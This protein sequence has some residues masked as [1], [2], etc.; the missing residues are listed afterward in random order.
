MKTPSGV[1]FWLSYL[2]ANPS[3]LESKVILTKADGV[4][5]LRSFKGK[6][7]CNGWESYAIALEE[8]G[9][10]YGLWAQLRPE[11]I[12]SAVQVAK[13][14]QD[15][16]CRYI[17]FAC[18]TSWKGHDIDAR[19]LLEQT[20]A[21]FD[22]AIGISMFGKAGGVQTWP[23]QEFKSADFLL[24]Q[25]YDMNESLGDNYQ[26]EVLK[27]WRDA[28]YSNVNIGLSTTKPVE[29]FTQD[30]DETP[31]DV[32]AVCWWEYSRTSAD[33]A[34]ALST[35]PRKLGF[36]EQQQEDQGR[37][38]VAGLLAGAAAAAGIL[39]VLGRANDD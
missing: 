2:P 7:Y 21:E 18:E 24:A 5:F 33:D 26:A 17:H 22:G 9:K 8:M 14:A 6:T 3:D 38:D 29:Q 4:H 12:P 39:Y 37:A 23:Y 31:E 16:A 20:R 36:D 35:L 10:E 30:Y 19:S 1:W 34:L 32:E 15:S 25:A 27:S 13:E 11:D 28:G